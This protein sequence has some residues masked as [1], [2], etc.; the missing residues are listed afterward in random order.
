MLC[1]LEE[2]KLKKKKKKNIL[3]KIY[4]LFLTC[5]K[6]R[7]FW[8]ELRAWLYTNIMIDISLDDRKILFSFDGKNDLVNYIYVLAKFYIYQNKFISMNI[9]IQGFINLLKKKMLSEK[10]VCFINNKLNKFLRNGH[11]CII[12]SF[13]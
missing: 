6:V 12:T 4:H 8:N 9:S 1:F 5:P 13:H 2:I 11:L 3:K 10:Y 7:H